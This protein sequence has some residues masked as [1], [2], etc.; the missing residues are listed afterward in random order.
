MSRTDRPVGGSDARGV[1]RYLVEAAALAALYFLTAKLSLR[2]ASI[3]PSAT[4]I[5]PPTGLAVGL[6]L[7]RGWRIWPAILVGAVAANLSTAGSLATS[8]AIGAGNML[9]ALTATL[10]LN[11][12]VE[13]VRAFRTPWG[14]GAFLAILGVIS[15]PISATIGV[16]ALAVGGFVNWSS[17]AA[18]WM[19]WWMGDF[20]GAVVVAPA[21][22]LWFSDWRRFARSMSRMAETIGVLSV[23]AI[24]GLIAY[25]PHSA[26][27]A[28]PALAFLAALPLLW[29]ALRC[30]E[31]D[32]AT[33]ALILSAIAVWGTVAGAGPFIRPTLND[34]FLLLVAFMV[35]IA[36]PSLALSAGMSQSARALIDSEHAHR[37]LV[38]G[39]R[40]Y[41]IFMLDPDGK[42]TTWNVGAAQ[43]YG[44]RA[45]EIIGEKVARLHKAEDV[46]DGEPD[47]LLERAAELGRIEV[48]GWRRRRDG[49]SF[50][51]SVVVNAIRDDQ[52]RL[53]GFAK[54]TRDISERLRAQEALDRT[55]EQLVQSQKLE[56]LGQLTGGIA[57]DFNNLLMII[58][59]QAELLNRRLVE[60]GHHKALDAILA[61]AGRGASLTRQLLSFSRRQTL[62]PE[63]VDLGQRLD[64]MTDMLRSSLGEAV[65]LVIDLDAALWPV[66]VDPAELE[67]ALINLAVNARDVMPDGGRFVISARNETLPDNDARTAGS[68]DYVSLSVADTG[69]G[70]APDIMAK[71]FDPF[72]TT[73]PLGKG[74]G[75]GL[76]QVHGFALQSGGFASAESR[77]GEGAR[78]TLHLPRSLGDVVAP[79]GGAPEGRAPEGRAPPEALPMATGNVLLVEDNPDVAEVTSALLRRLGCQV[80][81]ETNAEDALRRLEAG[82]LFEVVISDIIMP[83]AFDGLVLARRIRTDHPSIRVVL[84]TGYSKEAYEA[85]PGVEILRKPF[86]AEDLAAAL[87]SSL[88]DRDGHLARSG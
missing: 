68:Q 40:D 3:N 44:Y 27:G 75:L 76:S 42:L 70:M 84:A 2:F 78:F 35:T 33:V 31:R 82:E 4:P 64:A 74:T 32:T 18:V 45:E 23:A 16:C 71:V 10:L 54:I 15:A 56:A 26:P 58:S 73:K 47:R 50:W 9:E 60:D 22:V 7:V 79:H 51:A 48:E 57:H 12:W 87:S 1:V 20:A 49:G 39:V 36:A 21:L 8:L 14:I 41:A 72:F 46:A 61:A 13:G 24:V 17:F 65:A 52:G 80:A 81:V 30:G 28:A 6:M 53:A 77:P 34:S 25:G 19:T 66:E 37:L 67:L 59:G 86:G 63:T 5:W 29:A 11:R 85:E 88:A 43:I 62:T 69:P 55:R 83:G 38:E